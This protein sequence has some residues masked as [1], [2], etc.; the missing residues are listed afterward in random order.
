MRP[1]KSPGY[2]HLSK[3]Q[4]RENP[5]KETKKTWLGIQKGYYTRRGS[6]LNAAGVV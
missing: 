5:T 4:R 2:H 1:E 6:T 3:G